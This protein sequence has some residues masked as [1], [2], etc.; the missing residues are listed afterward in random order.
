MICSIGGF[1]VYA[2]E[3]PIKT[4]IIGGDYSYPPYE[5]VDK[6]GKST[7]Y[8]VELSQEIAE[9]MNLKIKIKLGKWSDIRARFDEGEI[10]IMQGM[11]ATKERVNLYEFSPHTFVNQSIFSRD[12]S[13]NINSLNDLENHEV[14][15]QHNGSVYDMLNNLNVNIKIISVES[16]ADALRLLSS[17]KHDYAMV[18]NLPGLYI[19]RELGL[20][21]IKPIFNIEGISKYGY[22][23]K[24]G[25]EV[26]LSQF[27][28]G[29]AIL[30]NTGRQQALYDKWF[31]VSQRT[32][33][34]EFGLIAAAIAVM[35][36]FISTAVVIW[37]K[38]LR[39]KVESRT[40]ELKAQQLQLLHADKMTSLGVLVSGVA[41]EINNPC[42]ILTLNFP[43]IKEVFEQISEILDEYET[44]DLTIAG[45]KYNRLKE[46]LPETLEDMHLASGKI[47]GIVEDLKH[48][49]LKDDATVSL[50]E[51]LDIN[52]LVKVSIRLVANQ[53]KNSTDSFEVNFSNNIPNFKGAGQRIEQVIIN[54]ILNACQALTNKTQKII[55]TTYFD[56]KRQHVVLTVTDHG[57]G[58]K[59]SDLN[60]LT[61][62]FYTSKRKQGGTGLGLSISAGIIRDHQGILNFSSTEGKH[63]KVKLSLPLS[64][65]KSKL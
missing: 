36:L 57:V 49:A 18:S 53:I 46:V 2:D 52:T 8:N 60:K 56:I 63:T 61:D 19:V 55:V 38:A 42:S 54:L 64:H 4:I 7:G 25:D 21:N 3:Q 48:F 65:Q 58:I 9:V 35:L 28:Q 41:H 34:S 39:K 26:L 16:H 62:P 47:R 32:A 33:W 13:S 31:G 22:A 40:Q 12:N 10:D 44:D 23:V 6:D 30:K 17:G 45:V 51:S 24:K 29:L 14:I 37:N 59:E 43:F 27:A 1:F 20:S 5:F 15:V 50:T 11:S